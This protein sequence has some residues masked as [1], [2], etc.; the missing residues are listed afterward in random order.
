MSRRATRVDA[1]LWAL[2][3]AL[4]LAGLPVGRVSPDGLAQAELA[5]QG[6]W[7]INPNHLLFEPVNAAWLALTRPLA[8]GTLPVDRLR[9]LSALCAAA[10]LALFRCWVAPRLASSRAAANYGTA[11][12]GL[13]AVFAL[14]ALSAET[15]ILQLPAV[16]LAAGLLLRLRQRRSPRLA[17]ALGAAV[18]AA[19]LCFV[20]NLLL[21]PA[22]A[23]AWLGSHEPTREGEE[24][25]RVVAIRKN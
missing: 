7:T 8:P 5:R 21:A 25:G 1:L 6:S 17:F 20:S 19:T 12:C 14:L 2:A 22:A 18:G 24:R 3:A 16:V 11:W 23:L 9:R 15:Y 13:C 10:A 4:L